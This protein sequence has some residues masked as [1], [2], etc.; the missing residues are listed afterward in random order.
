MARQKTNLDMERIKEQITKK[1]DNITKANKETGGAG[2]SQN[3]TSKL[4]NELSNS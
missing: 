2:G 1:M 3:D 4:M